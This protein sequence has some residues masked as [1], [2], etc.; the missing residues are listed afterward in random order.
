[1][2][3]KRNPMR[4]ERMCGLARFVISLAGSTAQTAAVQWMERTLD[5][6][7]NRRLVLPQSFLAAD[8]M[9]RLALNITRGMKANP[10]VI[11]RRVEEFLPYM[12][13]ENLMM[14]AV[15]RGAD[16]QKVH[17]VVR[18]RSQEVTAELKRGAPRNDLL[19]RLSREEVFQG[20]DFEQVLDRTSLVGRSPEQVDEF[21]KEVVEPIRRRYPN[22][23]GKTDE[24]SV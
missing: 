5:D 14:A 22:L 8:G 3:Y 4:S 13:T 1:M 6:S 19:D 7:V 12:A 10:D 15:A 16:R 24:V 20:M 23:L 21:L 17:K 11:R 9:L 2:A 18:D